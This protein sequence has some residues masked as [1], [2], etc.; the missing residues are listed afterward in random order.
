MCSRL[1]YRQHGLLIRMRKPSIKWAPW[2]RFAF[3]HDICEI[4]L[5]KISSIRLEPNLWSLELEHL[6]IP[7]FHN[8]FTFLQ[9]FVCWI[10]FKM[11]RIARCNCEIK[12]LVI[13]RAYKSLWFELNAQ[14]SQYYKGFTCETSFWLK[15]GFIGI[16][17][18]LMVIK[19][20]SKVHMYEHTIEK[21]R[22]RSS[23][24]HRFLRGHDL[25]FI[26]LAN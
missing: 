13:K 26:W 1:H 24:L 5:I 21:D 17:I 2:R 12:V 10:W 11:A 22:E 19:L 3:S 23:S 16:V 4:R 15:T 6:D 18:L 20:F 25:M 7:S 9:A 14:Q 8:R